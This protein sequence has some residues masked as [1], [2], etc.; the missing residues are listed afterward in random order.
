[1]PGDEQLEGLVLAS[2]MIIETMELT[3]KLLRSFVEGMEEDF[4]GA[5][6]AHQVIPGAGQELV[7]TR[8]EMGHAIGRFRDVSP[9]RVQER[10]V[11]MV[12]SDSDEVG[13]SRVLE[14]G[15]MVESEEKNVPDSPVYSA[16]CLSTS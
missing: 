6:F 3:I 4:E 7:V 15:E 11:I 16:A 2:W 14:E 10:P 5:P 1:M 9:V 8:D 12:Y 13:S